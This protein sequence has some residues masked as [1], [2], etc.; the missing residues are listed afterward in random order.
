[1]NVNKKYLAGNECKYALLRT[2]RRDR[3]FGF[4]LVF[5]RSNREL[6]LMK[7]EA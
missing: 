3:I 6:N 1:M 5:F 2:H 4:K 7:T